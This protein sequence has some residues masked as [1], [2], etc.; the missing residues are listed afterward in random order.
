MGRSGG[1]NG[2]RVEIFL[3]NAEAARLSTQEP[4]PQSRRVSWENRPR[5]RDLIHLTAVEVGGVGSASS[6]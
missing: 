3:A 5:R 1:A 2:R 6:A 4:R